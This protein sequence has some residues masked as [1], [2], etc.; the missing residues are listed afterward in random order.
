LYEAGE[1][2]SFGEEV[3]MSDGVFDEHAAE[4]DGWF[5]KN[6]N[7][8]QS[9]VELLAGFLEDPGKALSVGCGSGLFEMILRDVHDIE[10]RF[11]VE[12]AEGMAEIAVKRGMEVQVGS[13]EVLPFDDA[14]FDTVLFNGTPSYIAGLAQAFAEAHRVLRAGGQVVVAD[15]PAESSYGLLY[16]LAAHMGSWDDPRLRSLAP[17]HPYPVEFAAAANWRTTQE[18]LDLLGEVGFVG[19]ETAQTLTVHPRF[20][21]DAVEMPSPGHDRGDYVAI[22]ARK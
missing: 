17:A 8:L 10:V 19:P 11:G 2:W 3:H 21:D 20:S 13:A 14:S 16:R 22:R 1:V 6:R 4:Y 15:V 9:E 18:K 12:P 5:L 7:I